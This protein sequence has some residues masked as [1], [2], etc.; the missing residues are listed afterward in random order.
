VAKAVA[1]LFFA[2]TRPLFINTRNAPMLWKNAPTI[3]VIIPAPAK[4]I[5]T[6]LTEKAKTIF[7]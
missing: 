6:M 4:N 3:G 1:Y 5:I 2:I 7:W